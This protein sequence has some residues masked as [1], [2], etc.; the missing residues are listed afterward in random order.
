MDLSEGVAGLQD[1]KAGVPMQVCLI[2][3]IEYFTGETILPHVND[4]F[5]L[6][7]FNRYCTVVSPLILYF[8]I[9]LLRCEI[10]DDGQAPEFRLTPGMSTLLCLHSFLPLHFCQIYPNNLFHVHLLFSLS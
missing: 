6:Y 1:I 3:R 8:T 4:S 7:S 9:L 2:L 5:Y 10:V